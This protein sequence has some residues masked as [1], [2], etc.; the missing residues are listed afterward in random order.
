[1]LFM[2]K[3]RYLALIG[4][5]YLPFTLASDSVPKI[6]DSFIELRD[7]IGM[8]NSVSFLTRPIGKKWEVAIYDSQN[9][10][11]VFDGTKGSTMDLKPKS[12][13]TICRIVKKTELESYRCD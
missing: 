5:F 13:F 1:M 6:G 9:Y 12:T 8:P 2:K 7:K 11:Y 4:I 10:A 3:A